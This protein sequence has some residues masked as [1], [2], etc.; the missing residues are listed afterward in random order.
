MCPE[1]QR[2]VDSAA[3]QYRAKF[4]EMSCGGK[5]SVIARDGFVVLT[6]DKQGGRVLANNVQAITE[7]AMRQQVAAALFSVP[8]SD[9]CGA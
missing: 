1:I 5:W 9:Y 8:F 7:Q 4:Q 3:L 2:A 6:I